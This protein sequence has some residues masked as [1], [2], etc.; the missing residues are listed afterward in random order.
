MSL[1]D[2]PVTLVA[3]GKA[4]WRMARA[5]CDRL[6]QAIKQGI[7]ITKYGHS[8]G[9]IGDMLIR[10]A[11]HPLPDENSL[12]A[13]REA[14]AMTEGLGDDD[15]VLLLLS[16]GGSAL[17]EWPLIPFD[18][19][20]DICDRLV[21]SGLDIT[22]INT[23]RKR[24]SRVKGG[25]FACSCGQARIEAIILSD[26][27]GD[28]VDMIASGPVT[29][30]ISTAAEALDIIR[31]SGISLSPEAMACVGR[32]MP[33]VGDRAHVRVT[34]SVR[35][36]CAAAC[37]EARALGYDPMILTDAL[38]CEAREAGSML[39]SIART[40]AGSGRRALIFGGE[41]VVHCTGHGKGG[42]CQEI[43]LAA[44]DILDGAAGAAVFAFGSDGTDGPTDAAGGYADGATASELRKAGF[45]IANVLKDNDAYTAL[46]AC[47]GLI[48]T[49]PTGTNV[50][51]CAVVLTEA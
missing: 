50:N 1:G 26:V 45:D 27:L 47:G 37:A 25:G 43:A 4:A 12:A 15:T 22:S 21:R 35:A 42:R 11:G 34:G 19:Y 49:G 13:T 48:V 31:R 6:G 38:R 39:G 2:R 20:R 28:R 40:L 32:E 8:Q 46:K 10:E 30:D 44:A 24:L 33:T 23:V 16:G 29:Q 14:V 7:V 5:A 9:S 51:D 3:V 18:E 41:T 36:L 17:F